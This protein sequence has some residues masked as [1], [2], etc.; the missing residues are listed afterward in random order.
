MSITLYND[1]CLEIMDSMPDAF[2]DLIYTDPPYLKKYL[3]LYPEMAKR[4]KRIL[5]RGGSLISIVP[6]YAL[7]YP[8]ILEVNNYLKYRWIINMSQFK[9]NHP[10]M[11]MG[12]EVT[13]K[14]LIWWVNDAYKTKRGFV[15]DGFENSQPKKK[16][17][18][19]EQSLTWAEFML[20]F[21]R[22]DEIILDPFMGAGTTGIVCKK[23]N[24]NYIG[25]EFD[26]ETFK[27]A[28][29]NIG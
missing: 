23:H 9:G 17:H 5:K 4:A 21:I 19:W 22:I 26:S 7:Y 15:V 24:I 29:L 16:N 3:Y 25:I 1:N 8:E 10:R 28:Q 11:A 18:K 27:K 2:I 6:Q 12:I 20:K 13:W 14:P